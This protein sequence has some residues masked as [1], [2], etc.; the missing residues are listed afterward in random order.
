MST[1]PVPQNGLQSWFLF[2]KLVRLSTTTHGVDFKMYKNHG[3]NRATGSRTKFIDFSQFKV[4]FVVFI[5]VTATFTI[6]WYSTCL[7]SM[8]QNG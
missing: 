1:Y 2:L 4:N 7:Q 3:E 8:K 5:H 6:N